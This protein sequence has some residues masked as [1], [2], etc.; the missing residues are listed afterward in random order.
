LNLKDLG[1][2]QELE[3]K[4][5]QINNKKGNQVANAAE[6]YKWKKLMGDEF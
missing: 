6:K 5:N 1:W 3:N 4:F 2:N